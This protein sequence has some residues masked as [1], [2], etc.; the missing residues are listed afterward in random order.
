MTRTKLKDRIIPAYTKGEEMMNMITHIVGGAVGVVATVLCV[1]F[2]A[3]HHN[4]YGVVSGAIF[5][6]SLI[7]LYTMSSIYHGLNKEKTAKKVFQIIDH[8]SI[9]LLS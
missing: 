7:V 6:V 8:C 2:A 4:V 9:F 5:G 1:V 3:V